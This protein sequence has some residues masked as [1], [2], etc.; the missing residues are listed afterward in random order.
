MPFSKLYHFLTILHICTSQLI[1]ASGSLKESMGNRKILNVTEKKKRK[2]EREGGRR[3]ERET[4][5]ETKTE[6]KNRD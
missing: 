5:T 6:T 4:E 2:R 3:R 1:E